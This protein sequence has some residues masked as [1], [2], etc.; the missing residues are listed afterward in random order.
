MASSGDSR[1]LLSTPHP[2]AYRAKFYGMPFDV[3]YGSDILEIYEKAKKLMDYIRETGKPAVLETINYRWRGHFEGDLC[4]YRDEKEAEEARKKDGL[5]KFEKY[6]LSKK[7]MTKKEIEAMKQEIAEELADA[8][9]FGEE[10][11]AP[12]MDDVYTMMLAE[13]N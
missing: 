5:A 2:T 11:P 1:E 6:L 7:V 9:K 10:S 3:A 13:E 12:T 4:A 8:V